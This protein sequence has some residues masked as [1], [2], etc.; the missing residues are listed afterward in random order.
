MSSTSNGLRVFFIVHFF[1]PNMVFVSQFKIYKAKL[2]YIHKI[3][4]NTV[5]ISNI[6]SQSKSL[7]AAFPVNCIGVAT[8]E[9]F[10]VCE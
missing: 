4:I 5:L 9:L 3:S 10:Q 6:L 7:S 8:L 2:F 1:K